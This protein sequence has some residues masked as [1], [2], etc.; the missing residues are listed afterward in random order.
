MEASNTWGTD[1]QS[2]T[3]TVIDLPD[4]PSGTLAYWSL[5]ETSGSSYA[6]TYDGH[7]ASAPASAPAPDPG[8][9]VNGC[10]DFDGTGDYLTVPDHADFDWAYDSS[11]S[12]EV[13]ARF[14]N[15]GG[16]NKVF[17]G[18]D[19]D[20]G[21]PHWWLGANSSSGYANFNLLDTNHN[22][23]ACTGSVPLN[24]DQWHHL[25]AVRDESL[26]Q[27][28]LYV[29]GSLAAG[30][31]YD[32]TAGFEASTQLDIAYMAYNHTP[33]YFYDGKL[34]EIAIYDRAL[35][36]V[37]ISQHYINGLAGIG[38]CQLTT[39]QILST[40][41]TTGTEGVLYS[42][43]VDAS[44]NPPPAYSLTTSPAGMTIDPDSGLIQW[45]PSASGGYDVA[46]MASNSEGD[47]TQEFTIDVG[48]APSCPIGMTNYWPLD[49]QSGGGPYADVIGDADGTCTNCPTPT[50]GIVHGAQ[51][52]DGVG[53]EVN[54]AD[55]D[56]YD[57]ASDQSF[58]IAYWLHTTYSTAGN[59]VCVGRDDSGTNLH[60]WTGPN[61][62]GY[63]T[64][65]LRDTNGNGISINGGPVLN[66]GEWHY[67]TAVRDESLD[68]NRLYVDGEPVAS[69]THDYTAGFGSTVPLNIGFLNL[70][71]H[72]RYQG[73]L[74]EIS[75]YD[76]AVPA[77]EIKQNYLNGQAGYG[78]CHLFAPLIVSEA[79]TSAT[80]GE[81]YQYDVDA[82]GN[83]APSYLLLTAPE[84][85]TI[86]PNTGVI[87]WL[88]MTLG[89]FDVS[90]GV[91]NSQGVD[92]QSFTIH[93]NRPTGVPDEVPAQ[94]FLAAN[95]PNPFNPA[96]TIR[97]GLPVAGHVEL[98][99]FNIQGQRITTLVDELMPQGQHETT[100]Y[101]RDD[102]GNVMASG[103]Y[104]YRIKSGRFIQTRKMTLLK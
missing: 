37:E 33:A 54:A 95:H 81:A 29:D 1:T 20:G 55:D 6:D 79:D 15:V 87:D 31:P 71:G 2:F 58:T 77:P 17:V 100:W 48:A 43:D 65:Q 92:D 47:D 85:M 73:D 16:Q 76:R 28:R 25:V 38:Y 32:Y 46:V 41:I 75:L 98:A 50:A 104:F 70:S 86:D 62:D 45:T 44:G 35:T 27:N 101:G 103:I 94:F 74:D 22:G 60:W 11:F 59:R 51:Y 89:F 52:F 99:I 63:A 36:D 84:G 8:G 40:P 21:Y 7:D 42:Y 14:T 68:E 61:N 24:D 97:F 53:D 96:T 93:V 90:V 83:P 30:Q 72:Y 10:Q 12:I 64:F 102:R 67:F 5:D 9:V 57:W 19:E 78:A 91:A 34:D 4:C 39:P 23:V 66:D 49:E 18:R 82:A 26:D 3:I 69:N 13:W 56:N 88:P 80:A